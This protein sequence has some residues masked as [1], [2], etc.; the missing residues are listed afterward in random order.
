MSRA[1]RVVSPFLYVLAT[2][3]AAMLAVVLGLALTPLKMADTLSGSLAAT[4]SPIALSVAV[5]VALIVF[6]L[7]TR[8]LIAF[9][10]IA[11][12]RWVDHLRYCAA[13]YVAVLVL[14]LRLLV[15]WVGEAEFDTGLLPVLAIV[16]AAIL[17]NA[18]TLGWLMARE[19]R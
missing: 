5:A 12:P 11:H 6:V 16:L 15:D 9:E 3:G 1:A 10:Q 8:A 18:A 2:L 13:L 4:T 19:S 7:A 17:M 14:G